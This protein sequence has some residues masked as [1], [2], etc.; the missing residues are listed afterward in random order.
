MSTLT[1]RM[2]AFHR[3]SVTI[4]HGQSRPRI[5]PSITFAS[6]RASENP[7]GSPSRSAK[8]IRSGT[9]MGLNVFAWCRISSGVRGTNPQFFSHAE[10]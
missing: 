10:L 5:F 2:R 4:D 1:V 7:T 3:S 8:S 9:R 6:G